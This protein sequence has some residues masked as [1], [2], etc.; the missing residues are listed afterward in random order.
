MS[1]VA[2]QVTVADTAAILIVKAPQ[3]QEVNVHVTGTIYLGGSTVSNTTGYKMDNGDKVN[4][5]LAPNTDL[6]AVSAAGSTPTA[7]LVVTLL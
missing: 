7:Y 2:S 6:Y 1:T 4:F 3:Y 5:T